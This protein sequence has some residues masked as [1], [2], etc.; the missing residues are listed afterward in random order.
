MTSPCQTARMQKTDVMSH[1]MTSKMV[2][3]LATPLMASLLR[4]L[5]TWIVASVSPALGKMNAHQFREKVILRMPAMIAMVVM[6]KN[7]YAKST[8]NSPDMMPMMRTIS[9]SG[10][11]VSV[12]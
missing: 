3:A 5:P 9:P 6:K 1:M 2:K 7:Q 4:T 10:T 11:T 12:Q 8:M